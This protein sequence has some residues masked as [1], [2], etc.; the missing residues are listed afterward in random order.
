[1][2]SA[3]VVVA[4]EA[5]VLLYLQRL[6]PLNHSS[7]STTPPSQPL[8]YTHSTTRP[9]NYLKLVL[10]LGAPVLLS[11]PLILLYV[12]PITMA[13]VTLEQLDKAL[14]QAKQEPVQVY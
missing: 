6:L 5:G 10:H 13:L 3:R 8:D 12:H 4:V 11:F 7:L 2:L 1:M 9:L 14:Q